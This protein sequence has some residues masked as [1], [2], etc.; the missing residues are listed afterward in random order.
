MDWTAILTALLSGGGVI[1]IFYYKE[2]KRAKQLENEATASS[3]W[4]E[5]YEKSEIKCDAKDLKIDSLYKENGLLRDN[6]NDLTTQNAILKLQK[7]EIKGC[8]K[9]QPPRGY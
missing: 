1:G 8:E 6:N 7:C 3:Q 4:R 9:R 2:N 5:L